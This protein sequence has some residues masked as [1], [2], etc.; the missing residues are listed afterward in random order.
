M[1]RIPGDVLARAAVSSDSS[2][3]VRQG[4]DDVWNFII[5]GHGY[6]TLQAYRDWNTFEATEE[7]TVVAYLVEVVGHVVVPFEGREDE[8]FGFPNW[9]NSS[10]ISGP[11]IQGCGGTCDYDTIR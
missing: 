6:T 4:L 3:E 2:E 11:T 5:V 7:C 8:T 1:A 9:W 10:R